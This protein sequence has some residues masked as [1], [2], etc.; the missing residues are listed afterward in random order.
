MVSISLGSANISINDVRHAILSMLFS[1]DFKIDATDYIII[2][3]IRLPRVLIAFLVGAALALSG[4]IVQ[5]V[6]KNQLATPYTLGV[7]SGAS[8]GVGIMIIFSITLPMIGQFLMPLVGFVAAMVTVLCVIF[9][10]SKVDRN[11]TG[12]SIVLCGIILSLFLNATLM[13]ITTFSYDKIQEIY[14]WQLGSFAMRGWDHI[15]IFFPFILF[16]LC[17][18]VFYTKELDILCFSDDTASSMGVNTRTSKK[19][20]LIV[21]ALLTGA[22]VAICGII[23]FVDLVAPQLARRIVGP[24]HSIL[25]PMSGMVGGILLVVADAIARTIISPS[26]FPVGAITAVI[27]APFFAFIYLRKEKIHV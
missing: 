22:S 16:G 5:S 19:V 6:L 26:E 3:R 17:V 23:G 12:P 21:A 18:L 15:I 13:V 14:L 2:T 24:K 9:F 1:F 10:A 4:C 7:A 27:G 8:L 25:L 20:L 11:L